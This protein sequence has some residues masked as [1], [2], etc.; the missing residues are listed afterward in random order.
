MFASLSELML[1]LLAVS[2][3]HNVPTSLKNIPEKY[4]TT[5]R[6]WNSC[7]YRLIENLSICARLWRRERAGYV[8]FSVHAPTTYLILAKATDADEDTG[9]EVAD[10]G[11][12]RQAIIG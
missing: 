1:D 10:G 2:L 4:N 12:G 8:K 9:E 7:F 3:A 11:R 5:V 6:L